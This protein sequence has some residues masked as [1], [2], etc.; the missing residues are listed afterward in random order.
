MLCCF[1]VQIC[2]LK[3]VIQIQNTIW[4]TII[5]A[6][7]E[8]NTLQICK[9]KPWLNHTNYQ[10]LSLVYWPQILHATYRNVSKMADQS[11]LTN[12]RMHYVV[13]TVPSSGCLKLFFNSWE[14]TFSSSIACC[15]NVHY[16]VL[17]VTS[18]GRLKLYLNSSE[19]TCELC[20]FDVSRY[21]HYL[22]MLSFV[23]VN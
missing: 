7:A 6:L 1:H 5:L 8:K 4:N 20:L 10:Y 9:S 17:T 21:K 13:L 16:V 14:F 2:M 3:L 23:T 12:P 15:P 19:L 22:S 18:S 11:R